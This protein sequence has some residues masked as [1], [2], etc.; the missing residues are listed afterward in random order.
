MLGKGLKPVIVISA[1]NIIDGGALSVLK[2][3]LSHL[4]RNLTEKYRII[5]L[6]HKADLFEFNNIE[7]IGF[8]KSK[9]SWVF[10]IYYEY[11]YFKKISI[12]LNPYLWL[13]LHDMTPN[14]VAKI[15]AVYCHNPA[16]FYKISLNDVL[17]EPK[18]LLFNLFYKYLYK[19]NVN[20]NNFIVVQ[21][22]W[23]KEEFRKMAN[24][25]H[26]V[27]AHPEVEHFIEK[28]LLD[29]AE[30][31]ASKNHFK[32]FF[33]PA[34]PRVFKNYEVIC[35]AAEYLHKKG[36]S[37]FKIFL[38]IDGS[39]TKYSKRVVDKFKHI[40]SLIF[41]G[42]ISRE[43]VILKYSQVDCLI[44]PSKLETWGMPL[45]E[46]KLFNKPILASDLSYAKE[47]IGNYSMVK[48]FNP[49]NHIQLAQFIEHFLNGTIDFDKNDQ[50]KC[51]SLF[52]ENWKGLFEVLTKN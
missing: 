52:A 11:N 42:L 22:Q 35:Q 49:D 44:F 30:K 5:A 20:K 37:D 31:L 38:T 45:S 3:C 2:D 43:D 29:D 15:R 32:S 1:I 36:V 13:S 27:V 47:T 12:K 21:Q 14:V 50:N 17:Y 23:L 51:Y 24:L 25:P 6:V 28:E 33:Y 10:R 48:F 40:P 18:L 16:P 46:F 34:F 39:E 9:R 7:F 26:I 8:E 41:T 19:I 4:N